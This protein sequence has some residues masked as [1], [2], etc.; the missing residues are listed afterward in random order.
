[1]NFHAFVPSDH[2]VLDR[3]SYTW[4]PTCR[5]CGKLEGFNF[6]HMTL[7]KWTGCLVMALAFLGAVAVLG[8]FAHVLLP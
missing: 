8:I 5:V 2:D 1:M 4:Q 7:G 3:P 6:E